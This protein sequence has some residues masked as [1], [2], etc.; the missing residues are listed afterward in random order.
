MLMVT[1]L[2]SKALHD[3]GAF[4]QSL[5]TVIRRVSKCCD[6]SQFMHLHSFEST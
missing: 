1:Y 4:L 2:S 3:W 6:L 5:S